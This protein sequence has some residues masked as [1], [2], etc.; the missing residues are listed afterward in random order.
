V[1][2]QSQH[3]DAVTN[4]TVT[5]GSP[6]NVTMAMSPL[7]AAGQLQIVVT[8]GRNSLSQDLDAHLVLPGGSL[9]TGTDIFFFNKG[10]CAVVCLDQ[11]EVNG[12][13]PETITISQPTNGTYRFFVHNFTADEL[14]LGASDLSLAQSGAQV[15][16]RFGGSTIRSFTVPNQAGQL[17]TVFDLTFNGSTPVIT[18]VNTVIPVDLASPPAMLRAGASVKAAKQR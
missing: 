9:F 6:Q 2:K 17:W 11:D 5:A 3:V 14:D 13:G 18:A 10:N 12:G 16:V 1:A 8:W 4:V 7:L 15:D